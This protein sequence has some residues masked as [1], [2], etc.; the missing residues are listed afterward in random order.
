MI[1]ITTIRMIE[2]EEKD[3][4][5]ERIKNIHHQVNRDLH[6]QFLFQC[7][8]QNHHQVQKNNHDIVQKIMITWYCWLRTYQKI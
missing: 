7:H 5:K 4:K 1:N 3:I 2:K 6:H 8:N